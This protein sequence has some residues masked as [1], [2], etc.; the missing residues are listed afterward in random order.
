MFC[1][2]CSL[3]RGTKL[4]SL[5]YLFGMWIISSRKQSGNVP[6]PWHGP[7]SIFFSNIFFS[8]SRWT[9]ILHYE[10]PNHYPWYP[11]LSLVEDGTE[12]Q[13]SSHF[14]KRLGSLGTLPSVQVLKL[15]FDFSPINLPPANLTLRAARIT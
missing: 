6:L 2:Y 11:L 4:A 14:G 9:A 1:C 3:C 10:L 13:G 8:L 15:L 12:G 7:A 5:K